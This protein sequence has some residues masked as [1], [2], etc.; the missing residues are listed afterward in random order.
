MDVADDGPLHEITIAPPGP[1]ARSL[2][3]LDQILIQWSLRMARST[4][5][6]RC[7]SGTVVLTDGPRAMP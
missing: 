4:V 2:L 5:K 3:L 6:R 7:P 1:I